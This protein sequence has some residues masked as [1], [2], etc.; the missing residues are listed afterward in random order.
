MNSFMVYS[1][2][3]EI[4]DGEMGGHVHVLDKEKCIQLVDKPE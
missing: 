3:H 4:M 1:P 2:H